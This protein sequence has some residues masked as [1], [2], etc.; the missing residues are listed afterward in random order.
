VAI[1]VS[2]KGYMLFEVESVE[3]VVEI[4][5]WRLKSPVMIKFDLREIINE[6]RD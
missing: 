4:S 6:R 1:F 5:T 3:D 2:R